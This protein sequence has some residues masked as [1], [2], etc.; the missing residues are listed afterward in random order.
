[1][2]HLGPSLRRER[3]RERAGRRAA[4]ALAM[5][6]ALNA[7]AVFLVARAGAF[8]VRRGPRDAKP[9]SLAPISAAQW[10]ANR[11]LAGDATPPRSGAPRATTTSPAVPPPAPRPPPEPEEKV[12]GQV[13]D[14]APSRDRRRPSDARFLAEHD[15]TVEKQTRSRFAGERLWENTLPAPSPGVSAPPPAPAGGERG[16]AQR[17]TPGEERPAARGTGSERLALPHQPGQ[18][19]LA[20]APGG[21]RARDLAVGS[22]RHVDRV[23]GTGP[24]LE[25]PG[26]TDPGGGGRKAGAEGPL[27]PSAESLRRIV[28]GPS[29]DRLD[30][31]EEGDATALNARSFKYATFINRVQRAIVE[32]WDPNAAYEARD[33]QYRMF[34][35]R[36]RTTRI[37]VE[38]DAS[39]GLSRLD[40]TESCGLD[41]LD[42]D[43]LRAV[44][45]AAPF[46]NPPAGLADGD[47]KIRL[48]FGY[49]LVM[50]GH[51]PVLIVVPPATSSV[52]DRAYPTR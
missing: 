51:R 4:A 28:G 30:G 25:V 5:S 8:D 26:P 52:L 47:G 21:D 6:L 11:A 1:M 17:S 39:G 24:A 48:A 3:V 49:T 37:A 14:V 35:V 10:A 12:K 43:V 31:L 41:F 44:R 18:E 45:E 32:R 20:I 9:V 42:R 50:T 36:D 34:P 13:V 15:S 38:I 33:P 29:P 2:T 22:R 27:V 40:L 16:T 7:L 23:P 46:P 19:R